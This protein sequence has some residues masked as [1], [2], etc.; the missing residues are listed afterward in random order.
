MKIIEIYVSEKFQ[1]MIEK[2]GEMKVEHIHLKVITLHIMK[3]VF[4]FF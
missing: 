3:V 2:L 4:V 1:K